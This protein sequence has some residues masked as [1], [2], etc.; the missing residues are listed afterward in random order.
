MDEQLHARQVLHLGVLD[1]DKKQE[2]VPDVVVVFLVLFE[3]VLLPIENLHV[4]TANV[5]FRL[6]V[7]EK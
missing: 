3:T 7:L 4:H 6:F 2:V 1:V 5:A